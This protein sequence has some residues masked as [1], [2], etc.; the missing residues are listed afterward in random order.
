MEVVA[1]ATHIESISPLVTTIG[2]PTVFTVKG[3]NLPDGLGFTVGDCEHSNY[4][5][6]EGSSTQR[7]FLCTQFGDSGKKRGLVKTAPGGEVL[8][9]F[10]VT[11]ELHPRPNVYIS[12]NNYSFHDGDTVEVYLSTDMENA[13]ISREFYDLYV[14]IIAPGGNNA[15]DIPGP[16]FAA[17]PTPYLTNVQPTAEDD[18]VE[19]LK[20]SFVAN[21]SQVGEYQLHALLVPAG[22]GFPDEKG[23]MDNIVAQDSVTITYDPTADSVRKNTQ[24]GNTT[25][26]NNGTTGEVQI[27]S[28]ES[29]TRSRFTRSAVTTAMKIAMVVV[30]KGIGIFNKEKDVKK[31]QA[32]LQS[33]FDYYDALGDE[34]DDNQKELLFAAK[35][36]ELVYNNVDKVT[37]AK[38][39]EAKH[40]AD[41]VKGVFE[42]YNKHFMEIASMMNF[43]VKLSFYHTGLFSSFD[44]ERDLSVQVRPMVMYDPN[45]FFIGSNIK[46]TSLGDLAIYPSTAIEQAKHYFTADI[47]N[48]E[49]K[50]DGG[51]RYLEDAVPLPGLYA[52]M[53]TD[54]TTGL[55]YKQVHFFKAYKQDIYIYIDY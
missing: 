20:Y 39:W 16:G 21:D 2:S 30:K 25:R 6:G 10:E 55:Q 41:G 18:W 13:S 8:Y 40:L 54:K 48:F 50:S 5:T 4:E 52:V 53:V 49:V 46:P 29:L 33:A 31:K 45:Y 17:D 28:S 11:A 7:Q 36:L 14:V 1:P 19:T 9:T 35:V 42:L 26:A 47:A 37:G 44:S 22:A 27:P 23:E 24:N 51:S 3:Q 43:S 38:V 12:T 15:F 34:L 32:N